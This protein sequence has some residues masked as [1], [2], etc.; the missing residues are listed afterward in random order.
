[1]TFD[2]YVRDRGQ[3]LL[4]FAY[5]L[6]GDRHLAEDL[7]QTALLKAHG[8]WRWVRAADRPDAYLRRILV[9]AHLDW[10][11]RRSSTEL[12]VEPGDSWFGAASAADHAEGVAERARTWGALATLPPRQRAVLVL[13]FYEDCDDRAIAELLGCAESTVRSQ[14]S[15]ALAALRSSWTVGDEEKEPSP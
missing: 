1:M 9:N 5:L 10:R 6:T 4:R 11:R 8:R 14:A 12:P 2:E 3:A 13:R 15:R 7:V